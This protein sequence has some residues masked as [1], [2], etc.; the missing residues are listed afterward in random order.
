MSVLKYFYKNNFDTATLTPSSEVTQ[1]PAENVQ[2]DILST[3]WKTKDSFTIIENYN[4]T[5]GFKATSTGSV[6]VVSITSGTYTGGGLASQIQT[7]I[8]SAT[9]FEIEI[10]YSEQDYRSP[11][12]LDGS[13][14]SIAGI[15]APALAALD[16]THV[17]LVDSIDD[18]LRTY[19]WSGSA[20]SLDGSALSIAGVNEP[21]LTALDSTHVAFADGNLEVLR[22]YVW[23]GSAWSL[24]GAELSIAGVDTPVLTALDS[25][26]V[27]F[28]DQTLEF[29]R[30]YVWSG[31]AW[32]ADGSTL[33]IAGIGAPAL[34]ALDSTHVALIDS[35]LE[36]LSTYAWDGSDWSQVGSGLTISGIG[37]PALAALD[38]TH[39]AFIDSS[40][41]VLRAYVWSGSAWSLNGS[42]FPIAGVNY[43]ALTA[44]DS[45]HVAFIDSSLEVL[46]TYVGT[47]LSDNIFSFYTGATAT[48][49]SLF[50]EDY[51][52]S[53]IAIDLGYDKDSNYSDSLFYDGSV[54]LQSQSWMQATIASGT[55]THLVL[56]GYNMPAGTSVLVRLADQTSTFSG[57]RD[58]GSMSAS[59]SVSLSATRSIYA[60]PSTFTGKGVQLS[61][62]D[63]SVANTTVGRVWM[64]SAFTPANQIDDV[65][66]WSKHK[67]D[68]RSKKTYAYGGATYFDKK[69]S[70]D[71]YSVVV[72]P[73]DPYYSAA[74]KTG[75]ETF[76]DNVGDTKCFYTT[77]ESDLTK[78]VYGYVVGDDSYDRLKN[79]T[80]VLIKKLVIQEQ[81]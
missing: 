81:K 42:E 27:A 29:L 8:R 12:I 33:S 46:S 78:A 20:W 59:V 71:Q 52:S 76:L 3:V 19:V 4:D 68:K 62:H 1:M 2:V 7:Q 35:N 32:S 63:G 70:L 10:G 55:N 60:L 15:G 14:L 54:S 28:V 43:P 34:A 13:V 50:F 48:S 5:F 23:S 17:A 47:I 36:S 61:W 18:E 44:L 22:T 16:S 26:H 73:L 45:T 31:S 77:F 41:E 30:T 64:G 57:L 79:T 65:I 21:A 25:T 72:P 67:V 38:S 24:D 75:F 53:T 80:T 51:L 74:D 11:W 56:D 58:G 37:F 49:L 66:S 6:N 39:V 69:D 40:L 9:V